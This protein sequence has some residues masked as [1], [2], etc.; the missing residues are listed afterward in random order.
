MTTLKITCPAAKESLLVR[1]DL[2][3]ASS[4][5]QVDYLVGNGWEGSQWQCA[6]ARHSRDGLASIG[7]QL[8]TDAIQTEADEEHTT[9]YEI[10]DG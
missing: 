2:S 5:I 10:V 7:S 3:Q 8:L 1:C 9:T 4:P 6:D